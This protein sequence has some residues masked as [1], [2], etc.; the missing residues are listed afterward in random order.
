M[1]NKISQILDHLQLILQEES[2]KNCV[3]VEIFIN[4]TGCTIEFKTKSPEVL[5]RDGI[6]MRNLRGEWVEVEG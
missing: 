1:S 2:P 3:A 6:S 4:C 5:K